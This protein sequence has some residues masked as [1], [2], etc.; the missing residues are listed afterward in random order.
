MEGVAIHK[1]GQDGFILAVHEVAKGTLSFIK[2][3]PKV[4]TSKIGRP[5]APKQ[6]VAN[7]AN[8]YRLIGRQSQVWQLTAA[9]LVC[10]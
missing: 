3:K 4:Q 7:I 9:L 1:S 2:G 8:P 10:Y 5:V 6:L